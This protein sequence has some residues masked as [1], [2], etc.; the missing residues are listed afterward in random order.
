MDGSPHLRRA[1]ANDLAALIELRVALFREMGTVE[2]AG[3]AA[4]LAEATERY[5]SSAMPDGTFHAWIAEIDG[6]IV[7]TSGLTLLQRPPSPGNLTGLDAYVMNMYTRPE[8][9]GQGIGGRVLEAV[10]ADAREG[11]A[12]RIWLHA[13]EHGRA[14][15]ERF[16][17]VPEHAAM[18]LTW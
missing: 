3:T 2:D 17:F 15:Y 16:G 14:L 10:I 11:G 6:Q 13:T 5:L 12:R 7:A 9:R 8:W 4:E 1:N 18:E